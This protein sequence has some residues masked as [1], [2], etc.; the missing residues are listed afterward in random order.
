MTTYQRL[1]RESSPTLPG[2]PSLRSPTTGE[3]L[4]QDNIPQVQRF[5]QF[6]T[7]DWVEDELDEQKQRIAKNKHIRNRSNSLKDRILAQILNWLVLG[8]MGVTIGIIASAINIITSFLANIKTG[9]CKSNFYL[10]RAFC[11]WGQDEGKCTDWVQW[12]QFEVVNYFMFLISSILFAITAATLVKFYS[13]TAAGSGISEIKC[14]ISGFVMDGFLGWKT[15]FI[16]TLGLPLAIGSGLSLGKEGPSV[17]YAVC[18]GNSIAKLI[19]KYKKSAS[20]GREFLTATSAAGVAVAFGSPMGGVLFS[21]EE[22]TSMFQLTTIV[23][24]YF[25]AMIAVTTLAMINPFRTG[26]LVLFEVTYDTDWHYFEIPV[27]IILGIFGGFYGI[28]VSRFNIQM[29]AFRKKYLANFAIREVFTLALLTAS[30]AYFNEFLRLEMTESMQIL[31]HECEESFNHPLCDPKSNKTSLVVSL[32][33]ATIARMALVVITYG[34][35][36]PAGIFVPSMAVGAT[37][38]R[39]LGII[40]HMFYQSHPDSF[41]FKACAGDNGKCII[42]GTYAFLGAA[43]GLS[44][45]TDLTV[46]VVIIMFELTGALRYIVPT[47]IVVAITKSVNDKWGKGGIADQ[48]INVNGLPLIDTKE[49]FE[50]GTSVE[51]AMSPVVVAFSIAEPLTLSELNHIL[52]NTNYGGYPI[53][54]SAENPKLYGYISRYEIEY[55]L[56]TY[57][58][59]NVNTLCSWDIP[60]IDTVDFSPVVHKSP[61]SINVTTSLESVVDIFVKVGPKYILIETDDGLLVG[62]ITRKDI[63]RYHYTAHE[64]QSSLTEQQRVSNTNATIWEFMTLI[65]ISTRKNLGKLLYN[66]AGRYL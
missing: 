8:I 44:G 48:M 37:F 17:H 42:P 35:R 41:I 52:Q 60:D 39:A 59:V 24:S 3:W 16:K 19:L 25:C 63:L 6:R 47:M 50:F 36:V 54:T 38:G 7:I 11:C 9:H 65:G 1:S 20:K 30:F 66:D 55:I 18:V 23:K 22:M 14:I 56:G 5:H 40:I 49:E 64:D 29:T 10:S 51:S 46:T 4:N 32:L 34:C 45:I 61:I 13:P 58:G 15:L 21:I 26:Q 2:T 28:V 62:I 57:Q 43:A 33:F 27:Y 12:S 53:I 31:F